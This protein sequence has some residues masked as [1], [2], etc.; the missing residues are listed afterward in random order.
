LTN[1]QTY[2]GTPASLAALTSLQYQDYVAAV[3]AP[4]AL[5]L[6]SLGM[7]IVGWFRSRRRI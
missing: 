1:V 7:M 5:A 2:G 4:G 6:G 3:P